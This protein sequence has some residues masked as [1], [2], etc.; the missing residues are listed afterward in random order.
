MVAREQGAKRIALESSAAIGDSRTMASCR[1]AA[2]ERMQNPATMQL[3]RRILRIGSDFCGSVTE[4]FLVS[5]AIQDWA[6]RGLAIRVLAMIAK[7]TKS[8]AGDGSKG[9]RN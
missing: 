8:A 2:P 1:K 9:R 6:I 5:D 7:K 4:G 3:A